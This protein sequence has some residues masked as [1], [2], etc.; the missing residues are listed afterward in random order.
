VEALTANQKAYEALFAEEVK[1]IQDNQP[2]DLQKYK[3]EKEK[4]ID[5]IMADLRASRP[6]PRR[7]LSKKSGS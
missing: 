1:F 3:R 7:G 5:L 2:Y 4:T 6:P